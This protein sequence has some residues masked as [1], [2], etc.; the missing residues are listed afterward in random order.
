MKRTIPAVALTLTLVAPWVGANVRESGSTPPLDVD[1][2]GDEYASGDFG[3]VRHMDGNLTLARGFVPYEDGFESATIN[4]P[5]YPGDAAWTGSQDRAEIQIA[6]GSL[7]RIDRDTELWFQA[8]PDPYAEVRDNTVLALTAGAMQIRAI[9]REDELFRVDTP[10]A[11]VYLLDSGDYRIEVGEDGRTRVSSNRGVLEVSGDEGSVLVR[12]GMTTIAYPGE[13][14]MDPEPFNTLAMDRFARWIAQR[15]ETHRAAGKALYGD[16]ELAYGGIPSEIRPYYGELADSGEWVYLEDHGW[17]WYPL[18]VGARWQ[19]YRDG[20]WNYGP[21]GWFWVSHESWGWAPYH[22][23]RWNWAPGFGW[24]WS[25]GRWFAGAWVDWSWGVTHI[26][27]APRTSWGVSVGYGGSYAT[28]HVVRESWTYV[29]YETITNRHV[30]RHAVPYRDIPSERDGRVRSTRPPRVSPRDLASDSSARRA[31]LRDARAN[32]SRDDTTRAGRAAFRDTE[33]RWIRNGG[34]AAR[35]RTVA[36]AR[37]VRRNEISSGARRTPVVTRRDRPAA[38]SRREAPA[39]TPRGDS[40]ERVRA[41][42]RRLGETG[43]RANAQP[44]SERRVESPRVNPG[45]QSTARTRPSRQG[46]AGSNDR[47]SPRVTAPSRRSTSTASRPSPAI[48]GRGSDRAR[49]DDAASSRRDAVSR[50]RTDPRT[51]SERSRPAADVAPTRKSKPADTVRRRSP[52]S[53]MEKRE[54]RSVTG[55]R[56]NEPSVSGSPRAPSA[57]PA[58]APSRSRTTSRAAPAP[59]RS[60]SRGTSGSRP[61]ASSGSSSGSRKAERVA[62]SRSS[63]GGGKSRSHSGSRSS[64]SDSRGRSGRK[65]R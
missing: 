19:P 56:R 65:T 6:D 27:W 7:V 12:G 29:E 62:P 59:S 44:R 42:Y 55:S 63:S 60:K 46:A 52:T 31:G 53:V 10:G 36:E 50:S 32:A 24:C 61:A 9:V 8:L 3:R 58:P 25:P 20:Y 16:E 1:A 23:G 48:V 22:Y 11:T 51:R 4:S 54:S 38:A 21:G 26:G 41:W 47:R 45:S 57:R 14:P 43:D 64:S 28:T 34:R 13:I 35:V 17:S 5:V 37:D 39:V 33:D 49:P 40:G 30:K 18:D 2:Y 15:D